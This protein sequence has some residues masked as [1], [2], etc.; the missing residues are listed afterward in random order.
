MD[1]FVELKD[2]TWH[3]RVIQGV[4]IKLPSFYDAHGYENWETAR[5][6]SLRQHLKPGMQYYEIGTFEG[7]QNV[8]LND[9]L[10]GSP[11][12]LVE[13]VKE[14]W[15]NIRAI[16]EVNQVPAPRFTFPGF[17]GLMPRTPTVYNG[18]PTD[19]IDYSRLI[20]VTKFNHL[21]EDILGKV[22]CITLDNLVKHTGDK[23]D[24]IGVD[25]EGAGL[26]VLQSATLTIALHHP[27][28]WVSIHGDAIFTNRPLSSY[29]NENDIP[30]WLSQFGYVGEFLG[31]D[32]ERHYRFW[33]E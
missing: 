4:P 2:V 32:H 20:S 28:I 14:N 30:I 3:D 22:P 27:M 8:I 25:V 12:I 1:T 24:A 29:P 21:D 10:G 16:F 5:Y 17:V 9:F 13:P 11:Q 33:H 18:W 6:N 7:H 15:A 19:E 31:E 26:E 23:V